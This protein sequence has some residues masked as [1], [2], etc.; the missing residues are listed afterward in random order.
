[1]WQ[2]SDFAPRPQ[3]NTPQYQRN[4]SWDANNNENKIDNNQFPSISIFTPITPKTPNYHQTQHG[5][6]SH[7]NCSSPPLPRDSDEYSIFENFPVDLLSLPSPSLSSTSSHIINENNFS[8][9][10]TSNSAACG[11]STT[12]TRKIAC[13][14]CHHSKVLCDGIRPCQRCV[15]LHRGDQCVDRKSRVK[16]H[17]LLQLND[18]GEV[19][20]MN[21]NNKKRARE[22][23]QSTEN[24][25]PSS[26]STALSSSSSL[27]PSLS[28]PH[29][30]P[31]PQSNK[32][33]FFDDLTEIDPSG[34]FLSLTNIDISNSPAVY[35]SRVLLRASLRHSKYS[36]S[37]PYV[38]PL[39]QWLSFVRFHELL[40]PNDL[41]SLVHSF[42]SWNENNSLR[43]R[44]RNIKE[45]QCE[46]CQ[47]YHYL[48]KDDKNRPETDNKNH[49]TIYNSTIA[50]S[51]VSKYS[52][53]LTERSDD[54]LTGHCNG[55]V[56]QGTC[57]GAKQL[58]NETRLRCTFFSSLATPIED[59]D[60]INNFPCII[61]KI[62]TE[63]KQIMEYK[64]YM[65]EKFAGDWDKKSTAIHFPV[66][67]PI[68]IRVNRAF[69]RTFGIEQKNVR[70]AFIRHSWFALYMEFFARSEWSRLW[71][72]DIVGEHGENGDYQTT[73][74]CRHQLG[75]EF[76]ALIDKSFDRD[77]D[78]VCHS[79]KMTIIPMKHQ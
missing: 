65:R 3:Q 36:T 64:K 16:K 46:D 62:D 49:T 78:G 8:F 22:E 57:T 39:A 72:L 51:M 27:S 58:F 47:Q 43:S 37:R 5:N 73:A 2:Q 25:F 45:C 75:A 40:Q 7:F 61:M 32:S 31:M 53:P 24:I 71:E 26:S 70:S 67:Y 11:S 54:L 14:F 50:T 38:S 1:M 15:K 20:L 23:I 6:D 13:N 55:Q 66:E 10:D 74:L 29:P 9:P 35:L 21:Q 28:F 30:I 44:H 4:S 69:E 59:Y 33:S 34:E 52:V 41:T 68:N 63:N 79:W 17:P 60:S 42:S 19:S 48:L 77:D 56:C 76:P 18:L 12:T